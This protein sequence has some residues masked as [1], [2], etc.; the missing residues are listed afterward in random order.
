MSTL[1][2][3]QQGVEERLGRGKVW[4]EKDFG[5][6]RSGNEIDGSV[7]S[8]NFSTREYSSKLTVNVEYFHQVLTDAEG[9][10]KR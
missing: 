1:A 5:E 4:G 8:V 9:W 3:N 10:G 7:Y 6:G 2:S